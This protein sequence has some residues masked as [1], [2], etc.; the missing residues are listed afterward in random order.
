LKILLV[1]HTPWS[2][3]LGLAQCSIE[4]AE[5]FR[6]LGHDVDKFDLRDAFPR[7]TRLGAIFEGALFSRRAVAYVRRHASKY[8][9][10]Q[11]AQ[12]N[13]PVSKRTLGYDGV[14]VC[15]TDGL[16][17]FYVLWQ[18]DQQQRSVVPRP[19]R[20]NPL[21]RLLRW[22]AARMH[23]GL[24]AVNRSFAAADV[25]VLLNR[26]ELRFV[27]DELG[28]DDRAVLLPNG[29][30]ETRLRALA[31]AAHPPE[32]RL[33]AQH[34]VFIGHLSERKGL[35]DL[36]AIVHHVR[37]YAPGTRFS[38][39]G[40]SMSATRALD[41]FAPEDRPDIEIVERFASDE[42]PAL[43]AGKTV[44]ILP[45]YLEGFPLAVLELLAAAVPTVAYDVPGPREMLAQLECGL[46]TPAGDAVAF[47]E[48]V[49]RVLSLGAAEYAVLAA[50]CRAVAERF[51]WRD[52]ARDT[53]A[54][55][56]AASQRVRG[57]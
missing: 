55:Y 45:S 41:L 47:A 11:A 56:E 38:L 42:L 34:I 39:L 13:L 24:A 16:V 30:S 23:G 53:L 2:R 46:L 17:H 54:V 15:R 49:C 12:G 18:R 32:A 36:P 29:L 27:R 50:R 3:E 7:R 6:A 33:R 40:T 25:L 21:G 5:H 44:G 4:L 1:L 8:D 51:R 48:Q 9:V 28:H 14:L 52:I 26:D 43:L 20:G 10:I 31:S 57:A 35:A 22:L 37:R 19:A